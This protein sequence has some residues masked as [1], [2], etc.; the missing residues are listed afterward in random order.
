MPKFKNSNATF[1][2]IFKHCGQKDKTDFYDLLDKMLENEFQH[3]KVGFW[4]SF[5]QFAQ[6]Q[7]LDASIRNHCKNENKLK[8]FHKFIFSDF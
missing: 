6:L 2:V 1:R 3:G 8:K 7:N 5:D 4:K